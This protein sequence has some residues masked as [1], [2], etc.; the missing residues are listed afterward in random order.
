MRHLKE[1]SLYGRALL[2][3]INNPGIIKLLFHRAVFLNMN[4][5]K[6]KNRLQRNLFM[7]HLHNRRYEIA[8]VFLPSFMII[9]PRNIK[10]Y[11]KK[12]ET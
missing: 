6:R 2:F 4:M 8:L 9:C 12:Y 1:K 10:R 7:L 11:Q 3:D 5:T